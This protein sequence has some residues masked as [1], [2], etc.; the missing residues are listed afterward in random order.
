MSRV[1]NNG[2][3][4]GKTLLCSVGWFLGYKPPHHRGVKVTEFRI[5]AW[6]TP[7]ALGLF[8]SIAACRMLW[9]E[10]HTFLLQGRY[11]NVQVYVLL[12]EDFSQTQINKVGGEKGLWR[13]TRLMWSIL[14]RGWILAS[15]SGCGETILTLLAET[16]S[17]GKSTQ[18][19]FIRQ[20]PGARY[21]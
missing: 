10:G 6:H 2:S 11:A 9:T 15:P 8:S 21:L 19:V 1:L 4:R 5:G 14:C 13:E 3:L 17:S 12:I 20:P 16:S 7:P 18:Q